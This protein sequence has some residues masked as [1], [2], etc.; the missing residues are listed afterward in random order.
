[1]GGGAE[2]GWWAQYWA[3]PRARWEVGRKATARAG[4]KVAHFP[5]EMVTNHLPSLG[6][7]E[8]IVAAEG[9]PCRAH[10]SCRWELTGL[11]W[12]WW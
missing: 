9:G 8:R 5:A 11:G 3:W 6:R 2:A 4:E 12:P 10:P 1:M 7:S